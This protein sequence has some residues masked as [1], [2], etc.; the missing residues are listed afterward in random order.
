MCMLRVPTNTTSHRN[1]EVEHEE[2]ETVMEQHQEQEHQQQQEDEGNPAH[3]ENVNNGDVGDYQASLGK[4]DIE[5][6]AVLGKIPKLSD[7]ESMDDWHR[8]ILRYTLAVDN[9][10]EATLK[11]HRDALQARQQQQQEEGG[12]SL[13]DSVAAMIAGHVTPVSAATNNPP[14]PERE[15]ASEAE[16]L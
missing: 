4:E 12:S 13:V 9:C 6:A 7:Y 15:R 5:K 8:D 11:R 16:Q 3:E 2:E 10:D 14:P 1:K